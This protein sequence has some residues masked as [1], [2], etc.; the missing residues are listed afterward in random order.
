MGFLSLARLWADSL[1]QPLSFHGNLPVLLLCIP[2]PYLY[3]LPNSPKPISFFPSPAS[4]R[5]AKNVLTGVSVL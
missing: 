4:E 2:V 1:S 5:T 3:L